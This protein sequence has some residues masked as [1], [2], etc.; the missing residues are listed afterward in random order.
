MTFI[1]DI[2]G[3]SAPDAQ[4]LLR[5][6]RD[7]QCY[8]RG[9]N[10]DVPIGNLS[11]LTLTSMYHLDIFS[12]ELN[13]RGET[14]EFEGIT[15]SLKNSVPITSDQV[16]FCLVAAD[17]KHPIDEALYTRCSMRAAELHLTNDALRCFQPEDKT[18]DCLLVQLAIE[19]AQGR[20]MFGNGSGASTEDGALKVYN[21][22]PE[23][24]THVYETVESRHLASSMFI[25]NIDAIRVLVQDL[26]DHKK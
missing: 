25:A 4:F 9:K 10:P 26:I 22:H 8:N 16:G 2:I 19:Y 7:I 11:D 20:R 12:S 14:F 15:Y 18:K 21:M 17:N 24:L 1:L 23:V 5:P 3:R 6:L 13:G